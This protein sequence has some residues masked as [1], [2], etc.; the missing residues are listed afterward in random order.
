MKLYRKKLHQTVKGIKRDRNQKNGQMMKEREDINQKD[1]MS[2]K[3]E[4]VKG[5]DHGFMNS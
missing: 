5:A 3:Y 2:I 1:L 4:I